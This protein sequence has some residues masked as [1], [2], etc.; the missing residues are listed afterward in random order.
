ME[1]IFAY[2]WKSQTEK[3]KLKPGYKP[4]EDLEI[5]LK[6][7]TKMVAPFEMNGDIGGSL[8]SVGFIDSDLLLPKDICWTP[9]QSLNTKLVQLLVLKSVAIK[10]LNIKYKFN[11]RERI[12]PR[13]FILSK[14]HLVNL[15]L[16][17]QF[18]LF[19]DFE[20]KTYSDFEAH[21][22]KKENLILAYWREQISSRS[23]HTNSN[24][25]SKLKNLIAQQKKNDTVP[26]YLHASV[27]LPYR[28][29]NLSSSDSLSSTERACTEK[30]TQK[31]RNQKEFIEETDLN[32][33][34]SV[35]PTLHSFE[36][37][38][39]ADD[40]DGGRR[41]ESG[42][43]ELEAHSNSLDELELNRHTNTG[44]ASSLYQ[45]DSP[46][47]KLQKAGSTNTTSTQA[48]QYPEWNFRENNYIKSFCSVFPILPVE[49]IESENF[50]KI[51]LQKYKL[52]ITEWKNKINSIVNTP[53]WQNRLIEGSELDLDSIIRLKP[54]LIFFSGRPRI[55]AEKRKAENDISILI[56]ADVSYSTDTW[57]NGQKVID[58]IKD[59]IA[60]A[61]FVFEDI[62]NKVSVAITSSQTRKNIEFRE[63]KKFDETWNHFFRRSH[64]II[65]YQYTR[66]G[67]AI[68]HAI[69]VLSAEKS[70]K[71]IL[72]LITD[73]KPTDLDPYEGTYGQ[74]DV[75]KAIEEAKQRGLHVLT[76]TISDFD[77]A[78][79]KRA[80]DRPCSIKNPSDFC[81]E[82]FQFI[83]KTCLKN[84]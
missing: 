69:K 65:P 70:T 52:V 49:L 84:N 46:Q 24:F 17:Q 5:K 58:V 63:L 12:A 83:Q 8:W 48:H 19:L 3:N 9:N 79:L 28:E 81:R 7:F 18:P 1:K 47:F 43:D 82:I 36:K 53:K 26:I 27:P 13:L 59:S 25:D 50:K 57:I 29:L 39:S 74:Q 64:E 73:G 40:Y 51:V 71:P 80:F 32:K 61:S 20:K 44:E 67:P 15:W 33:Q 75:R 31:K 35:N 16:D 54:E 11:D 72:I 41:F 76:L 2:I 45:Q 66:L 10:K 60:V 22:P 4:L 38:E 62:F 77:P 6:N 42:D 14:M 68:R 37:M 34:G 23:L 55:F 56:L 21:L 30:K 78:S